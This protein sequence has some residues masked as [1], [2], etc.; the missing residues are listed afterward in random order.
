MTQIAALSRLIEWFAGQSEEVQAA[1]LGLHVPAD[2]ND[3][4]QTIL[5]RMARRDMSRKA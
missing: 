2:G 1:V 4:A 5:M 3:A